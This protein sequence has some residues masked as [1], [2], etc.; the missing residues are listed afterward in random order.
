M[1]YE[2]TERLTDA[3]FKRLAGIEPE[4]FELMLK[5]VVKRLSNFG[6]PPK[7]S[8]STHDDLTEKAVLETE[9]KNLEA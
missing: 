3:D 4:S 8:R 9:I 5:V 1:K 7:L 6:R 2:T